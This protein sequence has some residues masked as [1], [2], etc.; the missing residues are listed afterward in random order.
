M[1]LTTKIKDL[2][3]ISQKII[4]LNKLGSLFFFFLF[5]PSHLF[6]KFNFSINI[7]MV[8]GTGFLWLFD[9]FINMWFTW[10]TARVSLSCFSATWRDCNLGYLVYFFF[11]V[12]SGT[13]VID[14]VNFLIEI[15]FFKQPYS[16]LVRV[17][18][19]LA[20]L[21]IILLLFW[22]FYMR[23]SQPFHS[24]KCGQLCS[25]RKIFLNVT[26]VFSGYLKQHSLSDYSPN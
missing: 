26:V 13:L 1:I 4:S 12:V 6:L 9:L 15:N 11:A 18:E 17:F 23:G 24:E 14:S 3:V 19:N 5:F 2:S 22:C 16:C 20:L 10:Y 8:W 21:H 7:N 25:Y